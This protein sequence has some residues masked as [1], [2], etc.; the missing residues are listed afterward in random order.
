MSDIL[1]NKSS[2]R[3][4]QQPLIEALAERYPALTPA[5]RERVAQLVF[6]EVVKGLRSGKTL[7]FLEQR[8]DGSI[9]ISAFIVDR[10]LGKV[11]SGRNLRST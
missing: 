8:P 1:R 6:E 2:L 7:A 4:F 5:D 11:P 9:E 3:L 10:A